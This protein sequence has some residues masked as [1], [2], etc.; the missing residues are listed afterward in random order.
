M[1][2]EF[3]SVVCVVLTVSRW[4]LS[5]ETEELLHDTSVTIIEIA[6]TASNEKTNMYERFFNLKHFGVL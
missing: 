2:S 4:F 3:C 6:K 5:D 1:I